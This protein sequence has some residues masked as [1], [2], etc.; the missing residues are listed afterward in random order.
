MEV[1]RLYLVNAIKAR[2]FRMQSRGVEGVETRM[3][4]REREL[5]LLQ[6]AF[7]AA[8]AEPR[9]Q[10]VTVIGDAGIGK[11]RLLYEFENWIELHPARAYFFKGRALAI[12]RSAP[13]GLLR[14][15]LADRFDILDSDSPD[16]VAAKLRDG[17]GP[18]LGADEADV[19]GQWIGFDLRRERGGRRPARQRS[20]RSCGTRPPLPLRRIVGPRRPRRAVPRGSPLGGRGVAPRR[21]RARRPR[22]RRPPLGGRCRAADAPRTPR[23]RGPRRALDAGARAATARRRGDARAGRRDPAPRRRRARRADRARRRTRRRQRV[24]RRRAD[25]DA[26][27]RRGDRGRDGVGGVAAPR[28]SA[29]RR[30]MCRR[31]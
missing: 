11:S 19:V 13:F 2:R 27:R 17:L 22:H 23:V 15:V 10:R 8:V 4:G 1:S 14:D 5:A 20:T 21:R 6:G 16:T 25:Q 18:E 28:R 7:E 30:P 24:L 3:V 31:R 29:A 26:D 9:T 12:R